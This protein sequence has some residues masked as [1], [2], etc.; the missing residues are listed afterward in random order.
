M[1]FPP[2][3]C[4]LPEGEAEAGLPGSEGSG[5]GWE[6]RLNMDVNEGLSGRAEGT[7]VASGIE[8]QHPAFI[9]LV[10]RK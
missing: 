6:R 9:S 1:S 10:G 4:A 2:E 8:R 3:L 5:S 7:S